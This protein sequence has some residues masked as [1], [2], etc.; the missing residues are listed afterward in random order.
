MHIS[1]PNPNVCI[2]YKDKSGQSVLDILVAEHGVNS[3][4]DAIQAGQDMR[5]VS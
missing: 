5:T 2:T 1:D 3:I 4:A